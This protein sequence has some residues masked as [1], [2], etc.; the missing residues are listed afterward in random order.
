MK[1]IKYLVVVILLLLILSV[2][3]VGAQTSGAKYIGLR[4]VDPGVGKMLP[5]GFEHQGGG[6]IGDINADQ[7][8]GVSMLTKGKAKMF[9]L[10]ISTD[11]SEDGGVNAWEVKDVLEFSGLRSTDYVMEFGNPGFECSKNKT[12]L[13]S[14]IGIGVLNTSRGVFTPRKLWRPNSKT[15]KFES[16][17]TRNI[18]CIYS[19]P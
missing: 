19:E 16:V 4:Y 7:V 8:Y 12:I 9:W 13:E 17:S 14:L 10:Q 2:S 18:R 3:L 15:A 5:N 11:R 1:R 6:L